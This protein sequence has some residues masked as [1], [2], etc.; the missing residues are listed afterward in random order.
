MRTG[1]VL[2]LASLSAQLSAAPL[3]DLT[4]VI[5]G[6]ISPVCTIAQPL[7]NQDIT[8]SDAPGRHDVDFR[9]NC[10]VPMAVQMTSEHGGLEHDQY[11]NWP[12]SPGFSGFLPYRASFLVNATGAQAVVGESE[13]MREGVRG[14]INVAP[15]AA[16]ARLTIDWVP[17]AT[18]F[19]GT[20]R[21]TITIRVSGEGE[22]AIPRG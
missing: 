11:R 12:A 5:E 15:H 3:A 19:G 10:N 20:Y 21:D 14:F 6:T 4:L 1:L 9:V 17:E 16:T 7:P 2:L 8:L 13:R 22:S 18:L